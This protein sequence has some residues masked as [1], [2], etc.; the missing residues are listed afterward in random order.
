VNV[1]AEAREPEQHGG[2]DPVRQELL[3]PD[4][5]AAELV[6]LE[7]KNPAVGEEDHHHDGEVR[8]KAQRQHAEGKRGQ[9]AKKDERP[10][11]AQKFA[12]RSWK[13][14]KRPQRAL[15]KPSPGGPVPLRC[16]PPRPF[17]PVPTISRTPA[18]NQSS[19]HFSEKNLPVHELQFNS[20]RKR[21]RQSALIHLHQ[22][23]P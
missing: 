11:L 14:A 17:E 22:F 2:E 12:S 9:V 4:H 3:L 1:A 23:L 19:Y 10:V 6:V 20:S 16:R 15:R 21:L 13:S 8:S 7:R 18:E 5:P